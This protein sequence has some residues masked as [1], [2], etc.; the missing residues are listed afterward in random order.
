MS[1][2]QVRIFEFRIPAGGTQEEQFGRYWVEAFR[3]AIMAFPSLS[4]DAF[5]AVEFEIRPV[6][7]VS[8]GANPG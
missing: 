5:K 4:F 1:E 7:Y 3:I 6:S 8:S 2:P